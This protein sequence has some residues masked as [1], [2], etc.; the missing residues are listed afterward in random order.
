MA[1]KKIGIVLAADG[2]KD[3]RQAMANARKETQL[4]KSEITKLSAEYEGNANSLEY[5][6]KKQ[7][8]LEK[9]TKA[10]EKQIR[11]ASDGLKNAENVQ[12][13]AADRYEELKKE[14]DSARE[15]L[16]KMED[17]GKNGTKEYKDQ[18][19]AVASYEKVLQRQGNELGKCEGKVI[20]W[21]T[22]LVKAQGELEKT[23]R[24][25]QTNESY[26]KEAEAATDRCATSIDGYGNAVE[27]AT[28]VTTTLGDKLQQAFLNKGVSVGIDLLKQGADALKESLF[29]ASSASTQLAA[30][31]GLS[32]DAAQ[33]YQKVMQQIKGDNFG[34]DYGDVAD[35]MSQVIQIM[36][37]L[38]D[39]TMKDVTEGAITLRDTFGMDVN[40]SIR[41]VDVMMKTMGVDAKQAFNLIVTGAQNG[42]NRSGELVDNITEYGQL[43]GQAGFSAEEM[44]SILE[45]GLNS[46]AYN[47]DKV[48]DYVKEFGVS[49]ADGRIE[50]NLSS[51]ST[52]TQNLF[53]Q[54]KNGEAST[55]DVF[56]SVISD[57]E[58]MQNQQE[59][60]TIASEVWSALGEDNAMQVLT[61]LNDL[62]DGYTDVKGAMESLKEVKYSDLESSISGLGDAVQ[63]KFVAPLLDV[64][65][66][67]ITDAIQGITDII[68][69]PKTAMQEFTD[70]IGTANEEL[71]KTAESAAKTMENAEVEGSRLDALGEQLISLNGIEEKSAAQKMQMKAAVDA[72]SET[73]PQVAAAYDE[74]AGKISLTDGEIRKLISSK[75][76]LLVLEAAQQASQE[77]LNSLVEA[78]VKLRQAEDQKSALDDRLSLYQ[79][80]KDLLIE[81]NNLKNSGKMDQETYETTMLEF[82]QDALDNGRIS[83]EEFEEATANLDLSKIDKALGAV[84]GKIGDTGKEAK[85]LGKEIDTLTQTYNDANAEAE[86]YT[87]YV[88]DATEALFGEGEAANAA[89]EGILAQHEAHQKAQQSI[90]EAQQGNLKL[91]ESYQV[92]GQAAQAEANAVSAASEESADASERAADAQ[93]EAAE[94]IKSAFE[95]AKSEIQSGLQDKI[96]LFDLFEDSDGGEDITVEEMQKNLD[97]QIEAFEEYQKNLE[98]V[99]DHV[100][101]EIAPEFMQYLEGMGMDGA[102]TL[103]HILATFEDGEPEKVKELSD[104][105]LQAM[106]M[107]EGIA[108]V[109]AANQVAYEAAMGELGST[110]LEFDSLRESIEQAQASAAEGWSG[111]SDSVRTELETAVAAAQECGVMIPE[112]LTEGIA[113]GEVSPEAAI[114]SLEGGIRGQLEGL[115]QIAQECGIQIPEE[116]AAAIESGD[117]SAMVAAYDSLLGI[118]KEKSGEM[119]TQ[120]AE[121]MKAGQDGMQEAAAS[122]AQA[123]ADAMA[124]NTEGYTQAGEQIGDSIIQGIQNKG[125]EIQAAIAD[126]LSAGEGANENSAYM[127]IG[128]SVGDA[129][130]KGVENKKQAIQNAVSAAMSAEGVEGGDGFQSAGEQVA[131]MIAAGI[132]GGGQNIM[133]AASAA[134]QQ[135]AVAALNARTQYLNAGTEAARQFASGITGGAG[136]ASTA[137][138]NLAS[139][140]LSAVNSNQGSFRSAGSN[141]SAG[142]AAGISS[143]ASGAIAAARSMAASALAAAKAELDIHSPSRKFQKDVGEQISA[144]MAFGIKNKASL[145]GKQ[146]KT[147]S[148]KVYKEATSWLSKYKKSHEVSLADEKYYWQQVVKHTKKGTTA[149]NNAVK[150]LNTVKIQ[151]ASGLSS[152]VSSKIAGN[153]GVSRTTTTGS[154]KKKKTTKKSDADYYSE[155]YTA[156]KKY[157]DQQQILNE[158]S[159][160]QQLA[161]WQ[162]V[163]SRLKKGTDAWYD[164]TAQVKS[165]QQEQAQA[166][167]EAKEAAEKA[168]EEAEQ[169]AKE[170]LATHAQV[171]DDILSK[172]KTYYKVSAKAEA[173]YWNIARQQF[174]AGTDER[175]EA[176]QKYFDALQEWYDQRKELDEDYAE[177]AKDINDQL[178]EDIQDLQD[179]YK[180]AVA[181]RKE[182]ILSQMS[183]FEAWD[184]SGYDADT[185]LYN[186]KTQV[187][188]LTLWEQ[189]L[190]ELGKKGLASGLLEELKEMG[191]E[192]AANIYS[193]NQMT[194]AQLAEYNKLWQ[195]KEALAESQAVKDNEALRQETNS[196]IGQLRNEAQSELAALN[197]EYQAAIQELNTGISADLRNLVNKAGSI[198]E[199]AVSGMVG[200]I[201]RAADSVET[202]NS[203]TKVVNTVS[204]QLSVL[205]QEGSVIGKSTLDGILA[206]MMD[207]TKI[208]DTSKEVIQSIKRAM[209]EEA[210]IHSPSRLFR[211]ETGPQIPAGVAEGIQDGTKT[212]VKS[213]G[214][215]VQEMLEATQAE[216][217]RQQDTLQAQAARLNNSGITKLN[218]ALE[219]YQIPKTVVN[220]DNSSLATL[221]G[222]LIGAVNG[223]SEKMENQ[224]WVLDTGE[225]VAALQPQMDK[226]NGEMILIKNRGRYR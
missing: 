173:D 145:A 187:A 154:G 212:A 186:L 19:K 122:T 91:G 216:M 5:L 42:L 111:L 195:Q 175:I 1:G 140:A 191:P 64:A 55:K 137:A 36:G 157:V 93:E 206:G 180:D 50:D 142:V 184:S 189:Q 82:W 177:N 192:A 35:A 201:G 87:G 84:G 225:L 155:I 20:D 46:G 224:Q 90:E 158:W 28:E 126:V 51:F 56:Y 222:T 89:G 183:L 104:S 24:S 110:D 105:Y 132:T 83:L 123:G 14:V 205:A 204:S 88:E 52:G 17:A 109:G 33:K 167:A 44:F 10:Y 129:I 77:V 112:G 131:A 220:V 171:Q 26:L 190:E 22:K 58:K 16:K 163:Q 49:L 133:T 31:T 65:I 8:A 67:G 76:E 182:D 196:Q 176:D 47:L 114:A 39:G 156:A 141:M 73:V 30:S 211:R 78:E 48:N 185:L 203:T 43:W 219:S 66:P 144:G 146:A 213:S 162:Q 41:A 107:T 179:A 54:W 34:E 101:K 102:N 94:R 97:S 9:Q 115:A 210:Q 85:D 62:N 68:D 127:A 15:A 117:T 194:A 116:L 86:A 113:S 188:G 215:M 172:Y 168:K 165:L 21:Q 3:F 200:A 221:L 69:P 118:V 13:R 53:M 120:A 208:E 161:Y 29:D 74:E 92:V 119:S 153:F 12:K 72:L 95:D 143:G 148:N 135:G 96:S 223:L 170:R 11:N 6:Q 136:G 57:L 2:E 63:E 27:G 152:S 164:A 193:L 198:G 23:N 79:E 80:E 75:K 98:A 207:Y 71:S 70:E 166:A 217:K 139:R 32:E 199:E 134:M 25:L 99:K 4:Y 128:E 38:D 61:A 178:I 150:K 138:A 59:A 174:K 209:E 40:E 108:E 100:G 214:I 181:S 151:E 169:A 60:L 121:G 18:E 45:N 202:Y 81:I 7:A 226:A 147:M 103:K 149:Y 125:P 197:A 218:R 37:E 124:Q 130:A 160:Q 159:L 106:D